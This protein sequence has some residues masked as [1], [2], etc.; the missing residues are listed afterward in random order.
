MRARSM[1]TLI[2][3][4]SAS[5]NSIS[6]GSHTLSPGEGFVDVTGG[7]IWYRIVGRGP[8]TPLVLLHGGPGVP[9]VYLKPLEALADERPVVF[10]DQLG[11]GQSDRPKDNSLWTVQR[12]VE[13]VGEVRKGLGLNQIHLYC[14]SWGTMLA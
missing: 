1:M 4:V 8:G 5:L 13:E 11:S 12:F 2:A 3:I 9:S 7:R 6:C 10:Y 14:H